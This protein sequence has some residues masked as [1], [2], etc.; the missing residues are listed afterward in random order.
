[1]YRSK[2]KLED[3]LPEDLVT[4]KED[5]QELEK[6]TRRE[7]GGFG[8]EHERDRGNGRRGIGTGRGKR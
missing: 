4:G 8:S 1:M 7:T 5:F 6:R 3:D 2:N